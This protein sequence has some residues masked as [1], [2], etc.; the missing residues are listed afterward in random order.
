MVGLA[1]FVLCAFAGIRPDLPEALLAAYGLVAS[2]L[3]AAFGVA[4]SWRERLDDRPTAEAT[5]RTLE[6]SVAHI[7]LGSLYA[8]LGAVIA[9]V[10][11]VWGTPSP[12]MSLWG[13]APWDVGWR[14]M[15]LGGYSLLIAVST[16]IGVR[17]S[18]TFL[19]VANLLWRGYL[20][21]YGVGR[22]ATGVIER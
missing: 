6:E 17:L 8:T 1:A 20:A 10:V 13:E 12:N 2:S 22:D 15:H 4:A 14:G 11:I 18:L 9:V 3:L 5:K 19:M 16:A 21:A 7:L